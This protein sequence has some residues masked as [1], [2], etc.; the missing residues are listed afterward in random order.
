MT[1]YVTVQWVGILYRGV[2]I[3]WLTAHTEIP[4][5]VI[6][7]MITAVFQFTNVPGSMALRVDARLLDRYHG[8]NRRYD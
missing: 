5:T 3:T 2:S 6:A 8:M 7:T 4:A 1:F